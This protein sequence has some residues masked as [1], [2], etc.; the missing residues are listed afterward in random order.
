M[1]AMNILHYVNTTFAVL[2]KWKLDSF[3]E[4]KN[5]NLHLN[6]AD[7]IIIPKYRTTTMLI[8]SEADITVMEST[9][10]FKVNN[11]IYSTIVLKYYNI[12]YS[13]K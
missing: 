8:V 13:I 1:N 4:F 9:L 5:K 7:R 12:L 3:I 11:C 10:K 2:L 6:W